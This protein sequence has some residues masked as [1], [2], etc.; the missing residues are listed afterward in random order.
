M[1]E[2]ALPAGRKSDVS[3]SDFEA[4]TGG[5]CIADSISSALFISYKDAKGDISHRRISVRTVNRT[6]DGDILIKA[7][8]YERRSARSFRADRIIEA[9]DLTTGEVLDAPAVLECLGIEERELVSGKSR[10][11]TNQALRKCRHALN[12]LTYLARCDGHFHHEEENIIIHYL[13]NECFNCVFD[14][15][16]LL[17]RIRNHYPDTDTFFDSL[18]YLE[19]NAP[20][21]LKKI[22]K[23]SAQLVQADGV[24]SIKEN[25]FM[26]E[27]HGYLNAIA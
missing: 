6:D 7:Y 26:T 20:D 11:A 18:D 5:E 3:L 8:C 27:L 10:A 22:G 1:P 2:P 24:I 15:E 4:E 16:F 14:D 9:V 25:E 19:E 17:R 23:F 13:V 21:S 12:I